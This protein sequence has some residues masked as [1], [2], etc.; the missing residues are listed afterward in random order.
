MNVLSRQIATTALIPLL[1]ASPSLL[2][3][4]TA[5]WA[6]VSDAKTDGNRSIM[7]FELIERDQED[8]FLRVD[9]N[10]DSEISSDMKD[11]PPKAVWDA[12]HVRRI[13]DRE[14]YVFASSGRFIA[15]D[16]SHGAAAEASDLSAIIELSGSDFG[17]QCDE[18]DTEEAAGYF[19]QVV[20][21]S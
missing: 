17:I 11:L 15:F 12:K 18:V 10:Y 3:Q 7:Q 5:S 6:C 2:G 4:D 16:A 1:F 9:V 13:E 19:K 20:M 14:W 21:G 8:R